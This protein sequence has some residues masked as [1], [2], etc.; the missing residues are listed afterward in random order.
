LH[1]KRGRIAPARVD[2]F[3]ATGRVDVAFVIGASAV[4]PCILRW[5]A[6]PMHR[7]AMVVE[8]NPSPSLPDDLVAVCCP[9]KAGDVLPR[10]LEHA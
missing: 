3:L 5:A 6:I 4:F 10:L 8:I 9:H 2:A 7:G 1:A